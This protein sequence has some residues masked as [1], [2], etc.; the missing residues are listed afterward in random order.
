MISPH[1]VCLHCGKVR[2]ASEKDLTADPVVWAH[3]KHKCGARAL[4]I[5]PNKQEALKA[6]LQAN[7]G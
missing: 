5:Y 3:L 4:D 7:A 2:Q 1:I 6:A